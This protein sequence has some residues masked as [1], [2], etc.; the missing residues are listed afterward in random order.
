MKNYFHI[1]LTLHA[2]RNKI[3]FVSNGTRTRIFEYP[4]CLS[5]L[6]LSNRVNGIDG[7]IYLFSLLS[8]I[9]DK[10]AERVEGVARAPTLIVS[11]L[12]SDSPVV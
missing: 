12:E 4:D 5:A 10:A 8:A 6:E 1:I 9:S 2:E 11:Q 7:V 3:L